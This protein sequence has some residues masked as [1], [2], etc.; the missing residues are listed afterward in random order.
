MTL[1]LRTLLLC[2]SLAGLSLA[3]WAEDGGDGPTGGD[4]TSF[5]D[6]MDL[7]HNLDLIEVIV[8]S[9]AIDVARDTDAFLRD[10]EALD[11]EEAACGSAYSD[12][13]GPTVPSRCAEGEDCLRCYEEAVSK[14]NF[15]RFYIERARCIT[16]ANVRMANSA[17]AFGDSA[18]GIHA[19]TGLAWQLEGKP[20]IQ[21]AVEKLKRTYTEKAAVYLRNL[22]GSLK[23]LGRCE[24]EHYGEEDWYQRYGWVYHNFMKAKYQSAPE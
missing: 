17:M 16:A 4:W 7:D 23:A 3:A 6:G 24:A 8:E 21:E 20:Q 9:D 19:V 5:S 12:S 10:W 22:E 15:N 11:S 13:S 14:I 18:S 2:L 1:A